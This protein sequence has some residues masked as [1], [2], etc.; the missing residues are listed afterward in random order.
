MKKILV[1]LLCL[2][3]VLSF[4]L[5]ACQSTPAPTTTTAAAEVTT[6]AETTSA[7]GETYHIEMWQFAGESPD[8]FPGMQE[9]Y[10]NINAAYTANNPGITITTTVLPSRNRETRMMTAFAAGNGPDCAY[11]NSDILALFQ[12]N[13]VVV[14]IDDYV[15]NETIDLW[16]PEVLNQ[17]KIGGKLYGLPCL[18]DVSVPC[19]NL[20]LLAQVGVTEDDLPTTWD[21]FDQLL[22]KCAAGGITPIYLPIAAGPIL[23]NQY[24]MLFSEGCSV[25]DLSGEV[26]IDNPAGMK[27]FERIAKWFQNEWTPKDSISVSDQ[28][29]TFIEGTVATCLPMNSGFYVGVAPNF[30]FNWAAGQILAGDAGQVAS[31]TF[32]VFSVTKDCD[33]IPETVKFL[34]F[35]DNDEN[36][37]KWCD[38]S[39]YLSPHK[40][41]ESTNKDLKGYD[42]VI[43]S[44][45]LVKGNPDH[46]ISRTMSP[47]FISHTQAIASGSVTPAEGVANLKNDIQ[48]RIDEMVFLIENPYA[49]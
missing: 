36:N 16:I 30:P 47:L 1:L 2:T 32:A 11:I 41:Y 7:A 25:V 24:A 27:C 43:A 23:S 20:D 40:N 42:I 44:A 49:N 8:A 18:I 19:Y 6:E 34:E 28:N 17:A 13:D 35:F 9:L 39:G 46:A 45:G 12:F 48:E 4:A 10:D 3:I 33:N 29:G 26:T 37:L 5:G 38:F 15:T 31:G 22:E 21:E 14:P